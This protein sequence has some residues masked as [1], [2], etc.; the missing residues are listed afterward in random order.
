MREII[1]RMMYVQFLIVQD[2]IE[3]NIFFSYEIITVERFGCCEI[4]QCV[5]KSSS[6]YFFTFIITQ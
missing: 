3:N 1:R 5:P 4:T 6:L 2:V